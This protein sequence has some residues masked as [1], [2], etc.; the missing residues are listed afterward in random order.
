MIG[1]HHTSRHTSERSTGRKMKELMRLMYSTLMV[2]AAPAV[3]QLPS[4]SVPTFIS[5]E[6][7]LIGKYHYEE[8]NDGFKM[9]VHLN[10]DH[11]ALYRIRTGEDQADFINLTGFWTLDNP[12]IHIHNKP[13]RSA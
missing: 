4:N 2:I 12:Y 3:A 7:V 11:T 13:G 6:R 1:L 8:S 5:D 9:D 10:A